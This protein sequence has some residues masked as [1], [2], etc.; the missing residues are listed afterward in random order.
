MPEHEKAQSLRTG[1][2]GRS[3]RVKANEML[4]EKEIKTLLEQFF[5]Y[6]RNGGSDLMYMLHEHS[7]GYIFPFPFAHAA[8]DR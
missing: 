7:P 5:I 4:Y 1:E 2:E 8:P 3:E 6:T